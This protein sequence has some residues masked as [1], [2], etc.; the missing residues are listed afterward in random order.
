M[1]HSESCEAYKMNSHHVPLGQ[2]LG[3]IR[4]GKS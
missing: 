3:E 2:S 4:L 1:M